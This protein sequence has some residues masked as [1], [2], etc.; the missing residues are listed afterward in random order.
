MS[1]KK[2]ENFD[3]NSKVNIKFKIKKFKIKKF[4]IKKFKTKQLKTKKLKIKKFKIKK[5]EIKSP[6]FLKKSKTS[7]KNIEGIQKNPKI[8]CKTQKNYATI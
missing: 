7:E 3:N 6:N 1:N 5:F 8:Y 2:V 4:K